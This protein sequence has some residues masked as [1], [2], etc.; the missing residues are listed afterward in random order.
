MDGRRTA[1]DDVRT[2]VALRTPARVA[3]GARCTRSTVARAARNC[4][5]WPRDSR[6][7]TSPPTSRRCRPPTAASSRSW[8]R[9]R[10]SSTRCFCARSGSGNE[11]MLLD[12]VARRDAR[13]ARAAALLPDQQGTVVAPRSQSAVRARRAGE[14]GGRQLLS[15]GRVEGGDRALDAV[16]AGGR[17]RARDRILHRRFAADRTAASCSCPTASSTRTS[18]RGSR[19]CCARRRRWRRSR[20]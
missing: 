20:R 13:R 16:A 2:R 3:H 18:W 15:G 14:A 10:R 1:V 7:P 8:S 4:S 17:A 11:A 6:R 9:R 12:L 5:E 19:A